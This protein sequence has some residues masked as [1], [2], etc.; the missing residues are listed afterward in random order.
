MDK[1]ELE[2]IQGLDTQQWYDFH[3]KIFPLEVHG[4][5]SP[6]ETDGHGTLMDLDQNSFEHL[7]CMK[8]SLVAIDELDLADSRK[9]L[10]LVK[11]L[12]IRGLDYPGAS[13]L[14]ALIF[15]DWFGT[16]DR[17]ILES[18]SKIEVLA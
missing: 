7:F 9:Y 5:T 1:L 3:N 6:R 11:S 2:H 18:L 16:V 8:R 13:G 14:G 4:Q 12:R 10:N 17:C 15:K